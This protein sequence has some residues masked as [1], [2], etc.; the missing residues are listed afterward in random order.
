MFTTQ[1]NYG[2]HIPSSNIS[3]LFHNELHCYDEPSELK[4]IQT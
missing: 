1:I 2:I 4:E 3:Y